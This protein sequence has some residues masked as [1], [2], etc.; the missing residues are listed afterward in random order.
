[1]PEAQ[2]GEEIRGGK[3]S[4]PQAYGVVSALTLEGFGQCFLEDGL[5]LTPLSNM[6][7]PRE[8]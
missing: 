5:S 3:A 4:F 7:H 1:M 8:Y 6:T 2:V